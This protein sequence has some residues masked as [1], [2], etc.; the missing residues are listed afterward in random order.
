MGFRTVCECDGCG[1]TIDATNKL[2]AKV[3]VYPP[4]PREIGHQQDEHQLCDTC[5]QKLCLAF[6]KFKEAER[7]AQR[8]PPAPPRMALP[9]IADTWSQEQRESVLMILG[10]ALG[11]QIKHTVEEPEKE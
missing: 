10:E 4:T 7:F 5:W 11:V 6:P 3:N 1:E 8:P 2:P 9:A